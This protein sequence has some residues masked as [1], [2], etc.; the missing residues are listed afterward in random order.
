MP[1]YVEKN[2]LT[3]EYFVWQKPYIDLKPVLLII[4][5]FRFEGYDRLVEEYMKIEARE[6]SVLTGST[7]PYLYVSGKYK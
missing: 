5:D 1:E 6:K 2:K 3:L 7:L 4:N